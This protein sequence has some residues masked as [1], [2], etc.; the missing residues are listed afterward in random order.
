MDF[1]KLSKMIDELNENFDII[2]GNTKALEEAQLEDYKELFW[3]AHE[4]INNFYKLF[5]KMRFRDS[6]SFCI[7]TNKEFRD[8]YLDIRYSKSGG[9][10]QFG[11]HGFGTDDLYTVS[12]GT[13]NPKWFDAYFFNQPR[14]KNDIIPMIK[15]FD[16]A[17]MEKQFA[18]KL[19]EAIAQKAE[20]LENRYNKAK[21]R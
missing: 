8:D 1:D 21:E 14:F 11:Y 10:L 9:S 7:Y 5:Q 18:E 2:E 19:N 3:K 4:Y 15:K 12:L 13:V 20:Y 16:Y 6:R 17:Y